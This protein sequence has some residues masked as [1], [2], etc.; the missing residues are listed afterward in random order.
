MEDSQHAAH[1]KGVIHQRL[2]YAETTLRWHEV[3]LCWI[4]RFRLAMD[5]LPPTPVEKG[6]GNQNSLFNLQR[7]SKR[8]DTLAILGKVRVSKSTPKCQTIRTRTSKA[9]ISKPISVDSAVTVSSSTQQQMPKPREIKPRRA[10]EKALGQFLP[11]K[12]AKANR[13]A[14]TGT[15]SRSR[16]Q[17][18]GDG[19][20]RDR[21]RPQY[22][23]ANQRPR[24]TPRTIKTQSQ[25]I[26]REQV[27]WAPE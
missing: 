21:A 18:N 19:Q 23:S 11:Q 22:R 17:C 20:I 25:R 2:K 15:K 27:R 5:P 10:K 13:F 14:N 12:V 16:T 1:Q 8:R 26:S 3:I 7:R 6:S 4:E 9:T 24:F